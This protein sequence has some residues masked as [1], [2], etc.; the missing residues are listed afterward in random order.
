MNEK[1]ELTIELETG[2]GYRIQR[3]MVWKLEAQL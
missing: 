3:F 2:S 1:E